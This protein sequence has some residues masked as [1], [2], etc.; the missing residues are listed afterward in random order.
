MPVII[1]ATGIVSKGLKNQE[2]M[3]G[4]HSIDSVQKRGLLG[5]SHIVQEGDTV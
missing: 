5:A 4:K 2:R 3:P 1:G